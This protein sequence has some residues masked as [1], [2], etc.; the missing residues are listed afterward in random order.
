VAAVVAAFFGPAAVAGVAGRGVLA[1]GDLTPCGPNNAV[2]QNVCSRGDCVTALAASVAAGRS[3]RSYQTFKKKFSSCHA[4]E[5]YINAHPDGL[6]EAETSFQ[7]GGHMAYAFQGGRTHFEFGVTVVVAKTEYW[8]PHM[9]ARER[10]A[11]RTF[12]ARLLVHEEGH[13]AL[14]LSI[15]RKYRLYTYYA[16]EDDAVDAFNARLA[17]LQRELD[18]R[19]HDYDT[20]TR[21]RAL[22]SRGPKHGFP[23]GKDTDFNRPG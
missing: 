11:L 14:A 12:L 7:P 17:E 21:H 6:P 19:E 23:G 22:Q 3:A 15:A 8:W 20:W 4:L 16:S 18:S 10:K 13:R 9:T 1:Q 2:V 5:A